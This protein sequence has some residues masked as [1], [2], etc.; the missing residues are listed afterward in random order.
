MSLTEPILAHE[1]PD[2]ILY[3]STGIAFD[4]AQSFPI[5]HIMLA[6]YIRDKKYS[7][8]AKALE[9]AY[10]T[11]LEQERYNIELYSYT[12]HHEGFTSHTYVT[13]Q[14][15]FIFLLTK[16]SYNRRCAS[17][18]LTEFIG[19]FLS[20]FKNKISRCGEGELTKPARQLFFDLFEKYEDVE[21]IDALLRSQQKAE[22]AKNMMADNV[23]LLLENQETAERVLHQSEDLNREAAVFKKNTKKLKYSL[24]CRSKKVSII[25]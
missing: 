15:Y 10:Y 23:S 18:M 17:K 3:M 1:S 2:F 24:A 12:D 21:G 8:L 16:N 14:G 9:S 6:S 11:E 19:I 4:P 5:H 22:T 20:Q 13:K 25:L 7:K